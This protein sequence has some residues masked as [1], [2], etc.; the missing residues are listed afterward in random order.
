MTVRKAILI[1]L[2]LIISSFPLNVS[3]Q[4]SNE[5]IFLPLISGSSTSSLTM[6]D[7][8]Q[9]Y[10]DELYGFALVVPK[11]WHIIKAVSPG[12]I[13]QITSADYSIRLEFGVNLK[14]KPSN[15]DLETWSNN[16]E[17]Q[18]RLLNSIYLVHP[19]GYTM[20][21]QA[22][23]SIHDQKSS[24]SRFLIERAGKVFFIFIPDTSILVKSDVVA[25]LNSMEYVKEYAH[26]QNLHAHS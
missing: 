8:Q 11:E 10:L 24:S 21:R 4:D 3:G 23:F 22:F 5:S 12:D 18:K 19:N 25:L 9:N 26:K 6:S 7:E 14:D 1:G 17:F 2:L 13:T 15:V 16:D 20:P